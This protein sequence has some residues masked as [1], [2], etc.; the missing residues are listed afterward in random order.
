MAVDAFSVEVI[1]SVDVGISWVG[2]VVSRS[3]EVNVFVTV[4]IFWVDEVVSLV[5]NVVS[6][7]VDVNISVVSGN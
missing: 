7:V 5:V 6:T 2:V 4:V 1:F 3:V